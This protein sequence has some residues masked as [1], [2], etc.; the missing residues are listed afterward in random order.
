M[1]KLNDLS[2]AVLYTAFVMIIATVMGSVFKV[3]GSTYMYSPLLAVI[4]T[5]LVTGDIRKKEEWQ[6]LGLHRTGYHR[7]GFA[8]LVPML[9][10]SIAAIIKW[11]T[12][13]ASL[14]QP[15]QLA[16][17]MFWVLLIKIPLVFLF[18]TL[19]SA[20]GEEIGW[21]GYLLPKLK[22]LG[23]KKAI[24]LSGLIHAVFHFP[25]ILSGNYLNEGNPLVVI[26][27]FIVMTLIGGF[28]FG[29]L[30]LVTGSVWAPAIMH[31][32]HNISYAVLSDFTKT[33]SD[34]AEYVGGEAGIVVIILYALI[35]WF[36]IKKRNVTSE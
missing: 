27:F 1:L 36:I 35:V 20:I 17:S 13:F 33:H 10:L 19:T 3:Q 22:E 26:P 24:W 16:G 7:W 18:Y 15:E 31:S 23:W 6:S 30:R 2:K 11:A 25:I 28:L 5:L 21:R 4:V 32:S 12:P 8:L 29:Y 34:L 9:V 14:S